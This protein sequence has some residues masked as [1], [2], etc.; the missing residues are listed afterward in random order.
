MN[1]ELDNELLEKSK[2]LSIMELAEYFK[3]KPHFIV[4]WLKEVKQ[5]SNISENNFYNDKI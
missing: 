2:T 3:K 1:N 5:N 4:N